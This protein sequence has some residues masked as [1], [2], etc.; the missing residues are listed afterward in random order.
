MGGLPTVITEAEIDS[1]IEATD[2]VVAERAPAWNS[3]LG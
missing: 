3:A 2:R 1:V